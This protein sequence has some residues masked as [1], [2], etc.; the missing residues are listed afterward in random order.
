MTTFDP[1]GQPETAGT[2]SVTNNTSNLSPI[3]RLPS[4]LIEWLVVSMVYP[5]VVVSASATCGKAR[6]SL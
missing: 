1:Q 6:V 5:P 3:E 4:N 2:Q